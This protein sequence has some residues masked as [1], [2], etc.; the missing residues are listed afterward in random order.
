MSCFTEVKERLTMDEVV[1]H[2]G[3]TP[4]RS[5]FVPC[6]FHHGDR[7]PSLKVYPGNRGW[8]C[9]G[10]HRGGSVIDFPALLFGLSTL[11]AAK[12]LNDD[13]RLGVDLE[14]KELTPAERLKAA[15]EAQRRQEEQDSFDSFLEWRNDAINRL[16][17]CLRLANLIQTY[18]TPQ[19]M[20][21]MSELLVYVIQKEP[22]IEWW[23][24]VLSGDDVAAIMEIWRD[25]RV[26][27]SVCARILGASCHS[28]QN[29]MT[30]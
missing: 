13:F 16:N 29:T 21:E 26:V 27:N 28:S 8:Y 18:M 30:A 11:D 17:E 7:S 2:Y 10:C 9:F 24:D 14:R 20:G 25:R 6:P 12:K 22:L 23:S 1:R 4:S 3:F 15:Q 19:S 5:G